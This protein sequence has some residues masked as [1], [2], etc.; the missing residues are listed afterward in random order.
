MRSTSRASK[1]VGLAR[2]LSKLGFCS[3]SQAWVLIQ[4]R[5]VR[6]NGTVRAD[7]EWRVDLDRDRFEVEGEAVSAQAKFISCSISRGAL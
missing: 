4:K 2:A 7:P 1:P 6:V 5:R 3:R